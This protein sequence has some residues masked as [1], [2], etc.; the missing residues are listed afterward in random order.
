MNVESLHD[1]ENLILLLCDISLIS[2]FIDYGFKV[3]IIVKACFVGPPT[4]FQKKALIS[5][6]RNFLKT[7]IIT[8]L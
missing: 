6:S 8:A 7:Q 1:Y 5:N 2:N 4:Y 3:T